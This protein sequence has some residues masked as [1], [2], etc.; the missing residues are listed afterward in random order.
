MSANDYWAELQAANSGLR[1][2]DHAMTME[3][4]EFRRLILLAFE[5]GRESAKGDKSIFDA[6]FGDVKYT[7]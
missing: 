2:L 5:D 3:V 1:N 7:K 6:V 4:A